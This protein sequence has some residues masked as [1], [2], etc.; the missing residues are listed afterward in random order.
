MIDFLEKINGGGAFAR[1]LT[2]QFMS[3]SAIGL[4]SLP[5]HQVSSWIQ[6][7]IAAQKMWL[8][9]TALGLQ[10]HPVN[11]PL[12]FFYKNSVEKSLTLTENQKLY[13]TAAEK[14]LNTIFEKPENQ[15]AVFM[16]RVFRASASPERT[17]RKSNNKIFSIGRA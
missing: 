11:V 1:L 5:G 3:S 17:I 8:G 14:E 9:A 16:F 6:G 10:I 12:L 4:I 2:Q 7:G 15:T 13:L